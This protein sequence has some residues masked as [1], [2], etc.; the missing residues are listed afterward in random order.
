MGARQKLNGGHAS[1][2]II[3]AALIGAVTGSWFLF[4]VALAGLLV[5]KLV[6]GEIRLTRR[7]R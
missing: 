6:G 1:G 4:G 5:S 2:A 7:K 3:T